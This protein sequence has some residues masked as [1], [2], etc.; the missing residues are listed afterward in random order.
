[1]ERSA[2]K[3]RGASTN[4]L[5][6]CTCPTGAHSVTAVD[7]P[8]HSRHKAGASRR[9][10]SNSHSCAQPVSFRTSNVW[11]LSMMMPCNL[12]H[13]VHCACSSL[14]TNKK[15]G[16]KAGSMRTKLSLVGLHPEPGTL[17]LQT[18]CLQLNP[19]AAGS[20]DSATRPLCIVHGK[21]CSM[22]LSGNR[23]FPNSPL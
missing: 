10:A 14:V 15:L 20:S 7:A 2:E 8:A 1:M 4:Q 12:W 16:G 11:E 18:S 6:R 5:N 21:C 17:G 3:C 22:G 9:R 19:L 23:L 13:V